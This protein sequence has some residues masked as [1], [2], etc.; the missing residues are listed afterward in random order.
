MEG[1]APKRRRTNSHPPS[2][3]PS[4]T[5]RTFGTTEL[6]EL[7]LSHLPPLTLLT[8]APLVSR[9]W[10][11]LTT[12]SPP[13][14]QS[15]FLAPVPQTNTQA[16][17]LRHD[18]SVPEESFQADY[19]ED[20]H[21]NRRNERAVRAAGRGVSVSELSDNDADGEEIEELEEEEEEGISRPFDLDEPDAAIGVPRSAYS[22]AAIVPAKLAEASRVWT[23]DKIALVAR[24]NDLLLT[25]AEQAW[26]AG[27]LNLRAA[28]GEARLLVLPPADRPM[29]SSTARRML[30]TQPPATEVA[31]TVFVREPPAPLLSGCCNV[32]GARARHFQRVRRREGVR[33]GDVLDYVRWAIKR[34]REE[35][36]SFCQ[37]FGPPYLAEEVVDVALDFE[38]LVFAQTVAEWEEAERQVWVWGERE[39]AAEWKGQT[40]GEP[41]LWLG[42]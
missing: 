41:D 14:Q 1:P 16:W 28:N 5:A 9:T 30:L 39:K 10:N 33:Y 13:L 37:R 24:P 40:E 11:A 42:S 27:D 23:T 29:S 6:H 4:A 19:E 38:G 36:E 21:A 34:E 20:W 18:P 17:I 26:Q 3:Q 12:T 25:G 35:R 32:K 2:T 22:V 31:V 8:R 7:I 15:L